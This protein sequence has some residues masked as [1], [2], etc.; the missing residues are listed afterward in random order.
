MYW[1]Y[2]I[3]LNLCFESEFCICQYWNVTNCNCVLIVGSNIL[4]G[5]IYERD[6]I[7]SCCSLRY[8]R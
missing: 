1:Y 2:L 6:L 7:A 4:L 3:I 8:A 5:G